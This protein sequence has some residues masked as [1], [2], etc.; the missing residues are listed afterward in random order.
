ML[1]SKS[2]GRKRLMSQ[3]KQWRRRKFLFFLGDQ[4]FCPIQA[5]S[6]VDEAHVS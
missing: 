5:L 3:L 2:E 4:S 1:H 6:S